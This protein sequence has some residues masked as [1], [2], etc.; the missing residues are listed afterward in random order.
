MNWFFRKRRP[1]ATVAFNMIPRRGPYGGGNQWLNQLSSYLKS[2]G[3]A[4][5][6]H[7]DE[8]VDCVAGTH[9]GLSG[10]LATMPILAV[11]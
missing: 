7:L 1:V 3:Y 8:R 11:G 5:Q 10:G 9:A 6:F 4:V 2:C